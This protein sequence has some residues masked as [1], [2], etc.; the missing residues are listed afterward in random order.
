[1]V[2][3]NTYLTINMEGYYN[4]MFQQTSAG[5]RGSS[6]IDRITDPETVTSYL[7]GYSLRV[8]TLYL[9]WIHLVFDMFVLGISMIAATIISF[10]FYETQESNAT[11]Y[12]MT[13]NKNKLF[14]IDMYSKGTGTNLIF[15]ARK[16]IEM[17]FSFFILD[18]FIV[19]MTLCG[20]Y[21]DKIVLIVPYIV[22]IFTN[23]LLWFILIIAE[24]FF[25]VT[26]QMSGSWLVLIAV[27]LLL[28]KDLYRFTVL[29]SYFHM[30]GKHYF[31]PKLRTPK[32]LTTQSPHYPHKTVE[33]G[34]KMAM[35]VTT[36]TT[37]TEAPLVVSSQ[38][39]ASS[40]HSSD[41]DDII[42]IT[43]I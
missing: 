38:E 24:I 27:L 26:Q 36:T 22:P 4:N 11:L 33:M 2:I 31:A 42:S 13:A 14:D 29:Y 39:I 25:I 37:T 32:Y 43:D 16:L 35:P 41:E 12:T 7:C 21:L 5:R 15:M 34:T 18:A 23:I 17:I 19:A 6:T 9:L 3:A 20:V 40:D 1:M 8:C 30:I 10:D 28:V